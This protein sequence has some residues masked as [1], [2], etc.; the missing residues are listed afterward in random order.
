MKRGEVYF[1]RYDHSVG[2]EMA[3]GR[4]V[5][6]V[7]ADESRIG[8]A[9]VVYMTTSPREHNHS[10]QL[11]SKINGQP[12]LRDSWVICNQI[13][14]IDKSRLENPQYTVSDEEMA[15][16]D[17]ELKRVLGLGVDEYELD[18]Y[19]KMYN[20]ALSELAALTVKRDSSRGGERGTL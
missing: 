6:I 11:T 18:K 2:V 20:R 1:L 4:P 13:H 5:V 3:V 8:V 12:R 15:Q 14:T 10:V 17:N 16:I 7:S 19:K 9:N